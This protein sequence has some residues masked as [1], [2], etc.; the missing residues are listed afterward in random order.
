MYDK[1]RF[2]VLPLEDKNTSVDAALCEV[3]CSAP[4]FESPTALPVLA[5]LISGGDEI[6]VRILGDKRLLRFE[7]YVSVNWR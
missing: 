1:D 4:C 7:F 5:F 2:E 6:L 3:L